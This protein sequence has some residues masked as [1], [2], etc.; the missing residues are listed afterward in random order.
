[1]NTS[2]QVVAVKPVH[3]M[4]GVTNESFEINER[5]AAGKYELNLVGEGVRVSTTVIKR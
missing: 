1:V 5:L 4:P 3:Y 2:E